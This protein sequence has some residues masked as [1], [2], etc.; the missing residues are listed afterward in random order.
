MAEVKEE[1]IDYLTE[2]L[3]INNTSLA[4]Y[5]ADALLPNSV[6]DEVIRMREQEVIILRDRISQISTHISFIK[7]VFPSK[8]EQPRVSK[9]PV[10]QKRAKSKD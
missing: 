3:Q 8:N 2:Q 1:I 4:Q 6:P 7:K 10:Q 9:G 5:A